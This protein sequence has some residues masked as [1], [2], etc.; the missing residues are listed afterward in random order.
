MQKSSKQ[1]KTEIEKTKTFSKNIQKNKNNQKN[2]ADSS[3]KNQKSKVKKKSI[4]KTSE[5][6]DCN[7]NPM[8]RVVFVT[9]YSGKLPNLI[10]DISCFQDSCCFQG[11][12]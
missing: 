7:Q 4:E 8:L 6:F 2:Q 1:I 5:F 9:M 11:V 10:L 12:E 3:G